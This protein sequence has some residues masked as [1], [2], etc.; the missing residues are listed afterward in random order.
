LSKLYIKLREVSGGQVRTYAHRE[1]TRY[2]EVLLTEIEGGRRLMESWKAFKA[3]RQVLIDRK[4]AAR[5]ADFF[6]A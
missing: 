3:A 6:S 5:I 2:D 4:R 1:D